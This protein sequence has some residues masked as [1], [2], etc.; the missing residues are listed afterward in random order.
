MP[1]VHVHV[2]PRRAGDFKPNDKIYD[3]IQKKKSTLFPVALLL[4]IQRQNFT[5]ACRLIVSRFLK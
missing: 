2:L 4:R 5:K 3:A 1:H